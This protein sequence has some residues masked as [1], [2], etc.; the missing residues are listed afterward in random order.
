MV[1]QGAPATNTGRG[2]CAAGTSQCAEGAR[3][4]PTAGQGTAVCVGP[5]EPR[6][7]LS[8]GPCD[9]GGS[10]ALCGPRRLHLNEELR[11]SGGLAAAGLSVVHTPTIG[12]CPELHPCTS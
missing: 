12:Q 5:D 7:W 6:L 1:R 3:A 4:H 9:R 10:W 2:R 11:D 8:P